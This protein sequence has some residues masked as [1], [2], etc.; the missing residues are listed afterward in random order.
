MKPPIFR[1]TGG[2]AF[3]PGKAPTIFQDQAHLTLKQ[4]YRISTVQTAAGRTPV[5]LAMASRTIPPKS[6]LLDVSIAN[7]VQEPAETGKDDAGNK[8]KDPNMHRLCG[9]GATTVALSYWFNTATPGQRTFNDYV[10]ITT[11]NDNWHHAY[12]MYLATQIRWPGQR[13][14]PG[15]IT[16]NN[17]KSAGT[18]VQ[19]LVNTLNWAVYEARVSSSHSYTSAPYIWPNGFYSIEENPSKDQF[20]SDIVHDI[21]SAQVPAIALVNGPDLINDDWRGQWGQ[22]IGNLAQT[23]GFGTKIISQDGLWTAMTKI[24]NPPILIW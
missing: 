16:Y 20:H 14:V 5:Y 19:D 9:P 21:A 4:A 6:A 22:I 3:G 24:V 8:Y 11:W 2:V 12:I 15:E 18:N 7:A 1:S 23:H 10:A 13:G 17:G